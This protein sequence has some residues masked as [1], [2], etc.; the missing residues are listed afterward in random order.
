M[1]KH[2]HSGGLRFM[3]YDASATTSGGANTLRFPSNGFGGVT[4]T[5]SES[6]VYSRL[7]TVHMIAIIT[8]S[9]AT[10]T[11]TIRQ[12]DTTQMVGYLLTTGEVVNEYFFPVLQTSSTVLGAITAAVAHGGTLGFQPW[13]PSGLELPRGGFGIQITAAGLNLSAVRV[14][15]SVV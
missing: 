1:Y 13:I 12:G 7:A 2:A 14:W 10:Q 4:E 8:A 9:D 6:D 15:Y 3:D 5:F 11:L